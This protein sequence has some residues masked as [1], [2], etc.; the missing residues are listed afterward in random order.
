M[1]EAMLAAGELA[2]VPAA[3]VTHDTALAPPWLAR[4][5]AM[6]LASL[7]AA[8]SRALASPRLARAA[9]QRAR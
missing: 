3:P 5:L 6:A 2:A 8:L 1:C 7:R 9:A 4:A